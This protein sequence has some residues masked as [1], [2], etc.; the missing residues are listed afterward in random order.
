MASNYETAVLATAGLINYL[1]LDDASGVFADI[2]GSA[3][4]TSRGSI[5]Y[6]QTSLLADADDHGS[7]GFD[8]GATAAIDLASLAA[9]AGVPWTIE[10]LIAP[11]HF[12]AG[13]G[14]DSFRTIFGFNTNWRLLFA[15]DGALLLDQYGPGANYGAGYTGISLNDTGTHHIAFDV[16]SDQLRSI[17]IDGVHFAPDLFEANSA[18][19][20]AYLGAYDTPTSNFPFKGRQGHLAVYSTA[21][22]AADIQNH[23]RIA[24]NGTPTAVQVVTQAR[25]IARRFM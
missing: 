9:I 21:V 16:A 13:F 15:N 5:T 3:T 10:I 1:P 24:L 17:W 22:S 7:A 20:L 25:P 11:V 18:P 14:D 4:G 2:K 12:T 19:F 8:G 6:R 23:A